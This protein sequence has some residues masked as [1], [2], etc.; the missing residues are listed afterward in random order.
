MNFDL[1]FPASYRMEMVPDFP[2][3]AVPNLFYFPPR[4]TGGS[5]GGL[6][7]IAPENGDVWMGCFSPFTRTPTLL[8]APQP[9][10]LFV[11]ADCSG[12]AVNTLQPS[13]WSWI[14]SWPVT[15]VQTV[16]DQG[17]ILF[18]DDTTIT[19]YGYSGVIWT[20]EQ[21]CWDDLK[22]IGVDGDQVI[23]SGYD[24]PTDSEGRFV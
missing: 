11:V 19:A 10:W 15:G 2:G 21:V 5:E 1:T 14:K 16:R 7:R 6:L 12:Y 18:A 23:G 3:Y 4:G 9:D 8:A 20:S 22:I 13:E 17:M 24:P